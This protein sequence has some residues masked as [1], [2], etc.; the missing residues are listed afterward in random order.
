[1]SASTGVGRALLDGVL[2]LRGTAEAEAAIRAK[3]RRFMLVG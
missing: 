1:M 3:A 2:K